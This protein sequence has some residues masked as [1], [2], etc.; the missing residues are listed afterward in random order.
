MDNTQRPMD[1]Q[2]A[3]TAV[4]LE[5]PVEAGPSRS[6]IVDLQ[7]ALARQSTILV[8]VGPTAAGKTDLAVDL[9]ESLGGEIISADSRQVYRG[10]DIGTAKATSQQRARVPHH[11]LDVVNPDE[12]LTLAD[13]QRLA[14]AAIAGVHSRGC[15][16]LLVGGSG[17]YVRAVVEGWQIPSVPP[18]PALRAALEA[19]ARQVGTEALHARLAG[20]DPR[21]AA[22]IDHRNVRR[23]IRALEVCLRTGRPITELQTRR[24]PPWRVLW[25][26]VTRCRPELYARIDARVER[27]IAGGLVE[28]VERLAV[29]GYAWNLPAM[30]GLGYGQIGAYLRGEID[31]EIAI[32]LIKRGTRRFVQQQYNWFPLDDPA[33]RWVDPSIVSMQTVLE[34]LEGWLGEAK[35]SAARVPKDST[36]NL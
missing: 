9:A 32:A 34:L 8:V 30:T 12:V 19:V 22:R 20:L 2:R 11:L 17:L 4:P 26:G 27:M 3:T 15:L 18:D 29:A 21:A 33:I 28:E 6:S 36:T 31:L 14:F 10:M 25:L 24:P 5:A 35:D 23:V 1:Q 13:Y 16:P 7:P